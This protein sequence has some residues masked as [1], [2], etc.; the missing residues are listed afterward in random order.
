METLPRVSHEHHDRLWHIVRQ[1]GSLADCPDA[2]CLDTS[3]LRQIRPVVSEI[4]HDLTSLL[5]PHMEAVEAAVHPTLEGLLSDRR[6][7]VPM[8]R[9][10][11]KIRR[12]VAVIG[13]FVDHPEAHLERGTVLA[14]R[15]ALLR[16]C[17]LLKAHLAEEEMYLPI[18][19]GRL[20]PEQ[21]EDLAKALDHMAGV[22]L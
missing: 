19:E 8:A 7:M 16:L 3:R 21:A 13:G 15:R 6:A 1:L 5:I 10:H 12:L 11:V 9:E 20:T 18:L 2:D 17:A 4:H 14:L 22:A